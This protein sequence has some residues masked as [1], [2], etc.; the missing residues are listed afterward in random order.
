MKFKLTGNIAIGV[1]KGNLEKAAA[2]YETV[3]GLERGESSDSWIEIKSGPLTL[4]LVDDE[5]GTPTFEM[6][7]PDVDQAMEGFLGNDC[8]E[9]FLNENPKERYIRTL[10]GQFI[11]ISPIT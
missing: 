10:Y 8:K 3:L 6:L 2:Y 5:N 11:C 7:V 1:G 4:Y 9:V